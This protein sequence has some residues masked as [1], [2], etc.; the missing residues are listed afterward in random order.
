MARCRFRKIEV[1]KISFGLTDKWSCLFI[2]VS[3]FGRIFRFIL[4][5]RRW[6]WRIVVRLGN[7]WL[8]RYR[9]FYIR[10]RRASMEYFSIFFSFRFIIF[11]F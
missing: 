4:I 8:I 7:C 10:S 1:G 3:F 6:K 5:V 2:S 9:N 11:G